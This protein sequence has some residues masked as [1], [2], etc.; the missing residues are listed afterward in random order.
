MKMYMRH[1]LRRALPVVLHHVPVF[2][3]GHLTERPRN[4]G[5]I[6]AEGAGGF[7]GL[8][9][10]TLEGPVGARLARGWRLEVGEFAVVISG[11]E[12]DVTWR[13]GH[14]VEE[15]EDMRGGEDEVA[16]GVDFLWI[17]G[18][19][20]WRS[21]F[22]WVCSA[23]VAKGA[24]NGVEIVDRHGCRRVWKDVE[25]KMSVVDDEVRSSLDMSMPRL[26]EIAGFIDAVLN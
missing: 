22:C 4:D 2:D 12:K 15:R 14:Y 21:G 24:G 23:Y 1:D 7:N 19:R 25:G 9:S 20:D 16:L 11:G 13:Y 10:D 8:R 18:C 17:W 6:F 26:M 5:E 3:P